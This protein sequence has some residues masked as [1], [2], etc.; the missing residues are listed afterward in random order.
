MGLTR[1]AVSIAA[2]TILFLF[3]STYVLRMKKPE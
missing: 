2:S 1:K 3:Q